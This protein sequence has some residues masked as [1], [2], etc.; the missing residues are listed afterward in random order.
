MPPPSPPR[1]PLPRGFFCQQCFTLQLTTRM[2]A[3]R[4]LVFRGFV[5]LTYMD[6]IIPLLSSEVLFRN[7]YVSGHWLGIWSWAGGHGLVVLVVLPVAWAP[8]VRHAPMM[9]Q[10][11]M[12]QWRLW[13]RQSLGWTRRAAGAGRQSAEE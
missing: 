6:G 13:G 2:N 5:V 1:A 4:M 8:G 3:A 9:Q 7:D 10:A 11:R 12:G